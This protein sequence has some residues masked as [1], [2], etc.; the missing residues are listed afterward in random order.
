MTQASVNAL[1][2]DRQSSSEL[3]LSKWWTAAIVKMLNYQISIFKN[4]KEYE[5]VTYIHI[6]I[7]VRTMA[8]CRKM[9]SLHF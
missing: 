8:I 1:K 6:D 4:P 7:K 3:P 9:S 2:E 5:L